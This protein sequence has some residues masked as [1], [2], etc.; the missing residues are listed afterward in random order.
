MGAVAPKTNTVFLYVIS[1]EESI[2]EKHSILRGYEHLE[3]FKIK[4]LRIK[5]CFGRYSGHLQGD[6]I[7]S[8]IQNLQMGLT[9][10]PSLYD[11]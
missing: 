1:L 7:I 5:K 3:V 9:V 10:S 8:K 4:Y 2:E 6:V 11:N